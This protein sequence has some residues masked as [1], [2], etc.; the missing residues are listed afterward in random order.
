MKQACVL[1]LC[2]AALIAGLTAIHALAQATFLPGQFQTY[3][4]DGRTEMHQAPEVLPHFDAMMAA[5]RSRE[6]GIRALSDP[7]LVDLAADASAANFYFAGARV[8]DHRD[9]FEEL[10]RR[11]LAATGWIVDDYYR[12]LVAA[13]QWDDAAAL[14]NRFPDVSLEP[15]PTVIVAGGRPSGAHYWVLDPN[16]DAMARMPLEVSEGLVLVVISHPGCGFSRAAIRE[17]TT[18]PILDSALPARR[19]FVAPTFGGLRLDHI[20]KWNEANPKARHVLVDR[21]AEWRFVQKWSQPQFLFL[22]DGELVAALEGWPDSSQATV[23]KAASQ[24]AARRAEQAA[25]VE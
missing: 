16:R 8:E 2:R 20:R 14:V 18:N 17:M 24:S 12:T 3:V 23:L 1:V 25:G 19:I 6:G 11:D 22:V 9:L 4:E 5:V 13:R 15:L 10:V 7:A 21:P